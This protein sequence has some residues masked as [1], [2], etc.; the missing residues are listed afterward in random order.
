MSEKDEVFK[1]A[2]AGKK[3][4]VL[5]LDNKWHRLFEPSEVTPAIRKLEGKLN[6]LVKRQGKL[7]TDSKDIKK[8]KK[9]LMNEIVV[10]ADSRVQEPESKK[11]NKDMDD[12]KRLVEECNEKLDSYE[13]ELMTLPREIDKVNREL[14]LASMELCYKKI[15]TNEAEIASIDTWVTQVRRELKK[16]LVRKQEKEEANHRLYSYMHDI[17]GADVIELFDMK[18]RPKEADKKE[19]SRSRQRKN[20]KKE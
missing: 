19:T 7:N 2:L 8:I 5:T 18:Y 15:R 13:E 4:P 1:K 3:I 16:K 20:N 14:M 11:L 10:I 6:E 12:H 9:K 17:F